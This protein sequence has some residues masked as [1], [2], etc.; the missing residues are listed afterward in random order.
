MKSKQGWVEFHYY[1]F[2]LGETKLTGKR[3]LEFGKKKGP[4]RI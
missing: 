4:I 2:E 1:Y 3:K